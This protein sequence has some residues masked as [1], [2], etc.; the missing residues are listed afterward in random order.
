MA[1]VLA[2]VWPVSGEHLYAPDLF[3]ALN[4]GGN[5]VA[6]AFD[7]HGAMIGAAFGFLAHHRG[8]LVLH[9]HSVGVLEAAQHRGVGYA[10]KQHQFRWAQQHGLAAI[11][12]TFDPLLRRNAYF[13]LTKLGAQAVAY[14]P[15]FYGTMHDPANAGDETDR[16]LVEWRVAVSA[17]VRQL[18]ES[19]DHANEARVWIP[20]NMLALRRDDRDGAL[21]WRHTI[22]EQ[23]GGYINDGWVA[24]ALSRDGWYTLRK[25]NE[26]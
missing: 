13:N 8:E 22:R 11:T 1:A 4:F 10:I 3:T 2:T 14:L 18:S 19:P 15:N 21:R 5:Y 24:T 23:L 17:P 12:W 20:D 26:H 9:S 16:V 7:K 6:G 25:P